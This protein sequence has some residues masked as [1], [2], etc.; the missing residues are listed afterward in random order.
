MLRHNTNDSFYDSSIPTG[1]IEMRGSNR[2]D[3]SF[4]WEVTDDFTV[5]LSV[6]NILDNDTEEAVG[7]RNMGRSITANISVSL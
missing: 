6:I 1:F 3:L 2:L 4:R 5:R 7:F